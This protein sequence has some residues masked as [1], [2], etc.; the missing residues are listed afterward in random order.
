[1]AYVPTAEELSKALDDV[2][3]EIWQLAFLAALSASE[4]WLNNA[5]LE[6]RLLHVRNLLH[7]FEGS[8]RRKDDVLATDY[9]FPASAIAVEA[10]YRERLNK[11][12]THLTYSRTRRSASDRAWPHDRVIAPVLARCHSFAEHVLATRST[13]GAKTKHDWQSLLVTLE[14]ER[15]AFSS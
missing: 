9:G 7:F 5:I 6:S 3:Y 4:P 1:M 11:D 13:Y 14:K 12:L 2:Y 8:L 10:L 15:E